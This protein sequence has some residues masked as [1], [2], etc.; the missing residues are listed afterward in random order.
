MSEDRRRGV[1][2]EAVD[3]PGL[4]YMVFV[5]MEE[6]LDKLKLLHY[7]SSFC[8]QLGFKP[9][10]RYMFSLFIRLCF[11][12]FSVRRSVSILHFHFCVC[13]ILERCTTDRHL[14]FCSR[15]S[16]KSCQLLACK[17]NLRGKNRVSKQR[18]VLAPHQHGNVCVYLKL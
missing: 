7:E 17:I 6:F 2:T 4:Q 16:N 11:C 3:G 14:L 5:N 1:D 9:F 10:S 18:Q 13:T 8:R 15:K 12:E